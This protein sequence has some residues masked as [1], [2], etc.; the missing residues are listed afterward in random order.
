ML[1]KAYLFGVAG[2]VATP[3]HLVPHPWHVTWVH[4]GLFLLATV[5]AVIGFSRRP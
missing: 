4:M 1:K 2:I 3:V 5:C